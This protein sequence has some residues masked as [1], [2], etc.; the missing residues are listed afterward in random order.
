M[1]CALTFELQLMRIERRTIWEH[2]DK[3]R[4]ELG[5]RSYSTHLCFHTCGTV[6]VYGSPKDLIRL[7]IRTVNSS[8]PILRPLASFAVIQNLLG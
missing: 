7:T 8:Y 3:S 5:T 2:R 1:T 4:I 6:S